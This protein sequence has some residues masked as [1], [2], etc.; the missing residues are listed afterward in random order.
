MLSSLGRLIYVNLEQVLNIQGFVHYPLVVSLVNFGR[1]MEIKLLQLENTLLALVISVRFGRFID[2]KFPQLSNIEFASIFVKR[3]RS[4]EDIP[5][6]IN[7]LPSNDINFG[8][9]N[10]SS[11][12]HP[13]NPLPC[14]V[15]T[16]G[17][18]IVFRAEQV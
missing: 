11:E 14:I 12:L 5:Q 1:V 6:L 16:F 18:E 3:G 8:N 17:M 4:I 7:A 13:S 10:C 9:D 2:V 15:R